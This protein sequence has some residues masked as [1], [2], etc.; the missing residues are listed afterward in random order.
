[1]PDRPEDDFDVWEENAGPLADLEPLPRRRRGAVIL[2]V[3]LAIG[4]CLAI[5]GT[6]FQP[7][8]LR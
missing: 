7:A 2:L 5:L 6:L 3:A 1:M 8:V 4:V